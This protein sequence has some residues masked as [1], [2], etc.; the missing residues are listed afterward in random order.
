M[1][2]EARVAD[3]SVTAA[4]DTVQASLGDTVSVTVV[5]A[6]GGPFE[7]RGLEVQD[8][9]PTALSFVSATMTTGSYDDATGVWTIGD[10]SAGAADTLVV[11][12][13]VSDGTPALIG[14]IAESLGLVTEVDPNVVNNGVI[15]FLTIS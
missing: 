2:L 10:L 9:V 13:E 1:I 15:V 5:A 7:A 14:N 4:L 6:N 12:M 3:V 11:Q 8:S